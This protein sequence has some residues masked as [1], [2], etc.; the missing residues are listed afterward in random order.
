MKELVK[1]INDDPELTRRGAAYDLEL[2]LVNGNDRFLF[3]ITNGKLTAWH[4]N[5]EREAVNGFTLSGPPLSWSRFCEQVPPPEFHDIFAMLS[6]GHI[7]LTG[8]TGLLMSNILYVT[9]FMAHVRKLMLKE[10]AR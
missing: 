10:D 2:G 8:N 6:R 3:E 4:K 7:S 9:G 1:L 5:E